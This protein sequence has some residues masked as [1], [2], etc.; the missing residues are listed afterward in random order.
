M[1]ALNRLVGST[2]SLGTDFWS[3]RKK[4]Y[5]KD[6]INQQLIDYIEQQLQQGVSKKDV[7]DVLVLRGWKE[8]DIDEAFYLASK[9]S[10]SEAS[11]T[12]T[13]TASSP[14]QETKVKAPILV[15]IIAWLILLGG[16][17]SLLV[18]TPLLLI[19]GLGKSGVLFGLGGL[20]LVRGVGLVVVSFGLRQM[21]RW[22]LYAF[23]ALTILAVIV[24]IYSFAT[25]PKQ[26]LTEF[27][28]VAI[29]TLV[30]VYFWAI[31]KKFI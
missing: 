2:P 20:T 3:F 13:R 25:S 17:G 6:M 22:A 26:E 1:P 8:Q 31:S 4:C 9:Q 5:N 29:Q 18:T 15:T 28:D 24:S 12:P 30:L 21:R 19:G 11:P 10:S 23:T 14:V 7:K 16:I 27:I